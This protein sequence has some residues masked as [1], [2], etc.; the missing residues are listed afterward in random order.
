MIVGF[1][2]FATISITE[3]VS[4][5]DLTAQ[6][7]RRCSQLSIRCTAN[8]ASDMYALGVTMLWACKNFWTG[9][10][11]AYANICGMYEAVYENSADA[12]SGVWSLAEEYQDG[13]GEN[14]D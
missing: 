9:K 10:F 12:I 3:D 11:K 8:V 14:V 7:H 5:G 4:L 1:F 13:F 2:T 6:H